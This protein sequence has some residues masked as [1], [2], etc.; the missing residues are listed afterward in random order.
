[1]NLSPR[2]I[3]NKD[4]L[5]TVTLDYNSQVASLIRCNLMELNKKSQKHVVS[6]FGTQDGILMIKRFS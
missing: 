2:N 3:G 5:M 6:N 1:V 4:I